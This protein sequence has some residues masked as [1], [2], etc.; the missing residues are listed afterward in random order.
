LPVDVIGLSVEVSAITSGYG[1]TC[2]IAGDGA[3]KC[4]GNNGHGQVGDGTIVNRPA[5]VDVLGLR[6]AV[7]A[8]AAGYYHTCALM[9]FV[10]AGRIAC[11]GGNWSGQLGDGTTA[12]RTTPV[13]VVGFGGGFHRYL[14]LILRR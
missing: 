7:R 12:D 5:P 6:S 13:N 14:P 10:E 1:H 3:T 11:W 8:I 4:W 9:D 2:G